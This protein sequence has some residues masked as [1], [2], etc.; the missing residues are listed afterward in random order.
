VQTR[1]QGCIA[2]VQAQAPIC[3]CLF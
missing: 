2:S 1:T 3:H